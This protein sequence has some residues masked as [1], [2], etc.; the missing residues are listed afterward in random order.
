MR[1]RELVRRCRARLEWIPREQNGEADEES[2]AGLSV[3]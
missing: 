2:K 3:R 1:A